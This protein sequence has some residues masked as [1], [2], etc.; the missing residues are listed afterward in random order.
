MRALVVIAVVTLSAPATALA[1]RPG[2]LDRSFGGDGRVETRVSGGRPAVAG[3]ESVTGG[4]LLLG[5][6]VGRR[7]VV[8]LRYRRDGGLDRRFGRNGVASL[9]FDRDVALHD[10]LLDGGGRLLAVGAL[11][12]PNSSDREALVLRFDR[13]GH[14]DATFDTDGIALIDFGGRIG[15]TATGVALQP[16]GRLVIGATVDH[17]QSG[18]YGCCSWRDLGVARMDDAGRLDPTFGARGIAHMVPRPEE[19]LTAAAVGVQ[20]DG[21]IVLAANHS[22]VKGN[23]PLVV[24]LLA[25]GSPDAAFGRYEPGRRYGGGGGEGALSDLAVHPRTAAIVLAGSGIPHRSDGQQAVW[26]GHILPGDGPDWT[27]AGSTIAAR[28]RELGAAHVRI[29]GRDRALVAG[30]AWLSGHSAFEPDSR[31]ELAVARFDRSGAPST[32]FGTAGLARVSFRRTP[33][34]AA[35]LAIAGHGRV[36]VAGPAPTFASAT[37]P[38]TF[39]LA[40]LH[41]G[42][43][44]RR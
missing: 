24:R 21:A 40:R 43:C 32:C 37:V 36:V 7:Q 11:G 19:Y 30:T 34:T 9:T 2:T 17:G 27:R 29:D 13:A 28:K 10:T 18:L 39:R 42:R 26:L 16:D 33:S 31:A 3:I 22:S 14:L 1:A 4:K 23:A 12:P 41:N 8:L 44:P 25:D 35:G 38:P 6:T 20:P 15:D 5:G